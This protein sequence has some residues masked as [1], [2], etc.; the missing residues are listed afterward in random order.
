ME[1]VWRTST[2]RKRPTWV[3]IITLIAALAGFISYAGL[4]TASADEPVC[5]A[6]VKCAPNAQL[7]DDDT[8][9]RALDTG[10]NQAYFWSGR[11]DGNSVQDQAIAIAESRGGTTI[12]GLLER[13]DVT[14]PEYAPGDTTSE[15][16]WEKVS[17]YYADGA[18]GVVHVVMGTQLRENNIFETKELP[19]L[20]ANG[21]VV[22][23]VKVDA[24][25]GE[26]VEVL[27][28]RSGPPTDDDDSDSDSGDD[29]DNGS[30]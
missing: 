12:E 20:K 18:S 26:D 13:A 2:K 21:L 15:D 28:E 4:G 14:M 23:V 22:Q 11:V 25:T 29:N 16:A 1:S 24:Q 8:L 19:A 3:A 30:S 7:P 9:K 17:E 27:Y 6:A 10:P 5:A